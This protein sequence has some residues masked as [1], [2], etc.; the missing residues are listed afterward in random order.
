MLSLSIWMLIL[1]CI[2]N[3]Q[4]QSIRVIKSL[5]ELKRQP[6]DESPTMLR[7]NKKK[8]RELFQVTADELAGDELS[9]RPH[10]VLKRAL[11]SSG[12]AQNF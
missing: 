4:Q 5:D 10:S 9:N 3:V 8:V 2:G 11:N 12:K 7:L 1:V 6:R